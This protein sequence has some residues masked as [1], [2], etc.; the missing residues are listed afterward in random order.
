MVEYAGLGHV[1][2]RGHGALRMEHGKEGASRDY[3]SGTL[4]IFYRFQAR[5]Y[6]NRVYAKCLFQSADSHSLPLAPYG[7]PMKMQL[8]TNKMHGPSQM[9]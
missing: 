2:S 4:L 6:P 9:V 3:V 7:S 8:K 5:I 1:G